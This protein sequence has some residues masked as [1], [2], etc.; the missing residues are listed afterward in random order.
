MM[1]MGIKE[2]LKHMKQDEI[3]LRTLQRHVEILRGYLA[4]VVGPLYSECPE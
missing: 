3:E 4:E 2:V 1:A